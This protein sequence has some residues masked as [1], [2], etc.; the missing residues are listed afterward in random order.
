MTNE[1]K[2]QA[3]FM[4]TQIASAEHIAEEF[5]DA[6]SF[7]IIAED[8]KGPINGYRVSMTAAELR[9]PLVAVMETRLKGMRRHLAR[10]VG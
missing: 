8:A 7:V 10:L 3:T 6:V 2:T 4:S 9:G 5:R 1:Q